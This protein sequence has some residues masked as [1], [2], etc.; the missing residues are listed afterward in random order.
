MS[1]KNVA[2]GKSV[3]NPATR[4]GPTPI[5]GRGARLARAATIAGA[6]PLTVPRSLPRGLSSLPRE[7]VLVSQ[8]S[9]LVEAIA[10]EVAERGYGETTVA[11]IIERAGVSRTT[12]YELFK[13]KEDGFLQCFQAIANAQFDGVAEALTS[14][15]TLP[16]QLITALTAYMERVDK[17]RWFARAFLAEAEAAS[18]AIRQAFLEARVR[19]WQTIRFW[20]DRVRAAH[21]HVPECG[22]TAHQ[23]LMAGLSGFLNSQVRQDHSHLT[24][25]IP[26]IAAHFFA[27]LGLYRWARLMNE[28]GRATGSPR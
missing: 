22:E 4:R 7:I 6:G 13:D 24:D 15:R 19:L 11:H 27:S 18:P 25:E 28:R 2:P 23:L 16:D 3:R 9:R 8:R 17:D 5:A 20:F 21:P 10:H 1:A 26:A 12:F 14:E